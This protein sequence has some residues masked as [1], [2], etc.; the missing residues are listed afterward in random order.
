MYPEDFPNFVADKSNQAYIDN[1]SDALK[2]VRPAL[3]G[4]K[5]CCVKPGSNIKADKTH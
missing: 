1:S 4:G 2:K 3:V 5:N